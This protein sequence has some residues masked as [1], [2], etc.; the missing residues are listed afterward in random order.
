MRYLFGLY[1]VFSIFFS[2]FV[3]LIYQNS[4]QVL[5]QSKELSKISLTFKNMTT[6]ENAQKISKALMEKYKL[7]ETQILSPADQYADFLKS[8]SMYNQGAFDTDEILQLIPYAVDFIA[9]D[10]QDL[11]KIR[12]DILSQNIFQENNTSSEWLDKFKSIVLLI[13]NM[14]R[15]LFLFLFAST[16]LLTVATIRIIISEDDF[17]NKIRSYLGESFQ[18]IYRR[19]LW[20]MAKLYFVA[21]CIGFLMTYLVFNFFL[22][23]IKTNFNFAF[24]ADR[25]HFLSTDSILLMLAGFLTAFGFGAFVSLKQLFTRIYH[26]E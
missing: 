7:K 6:E 4:N 21:I 20:S 11:K 17:K 15:F 8:F 12:A 3:L 25:L 22:F 13:E 2:S 10:H 18:E 24:L 5:F 14:G 26:E 19:Y 1:L 16:S 9:F 23:K